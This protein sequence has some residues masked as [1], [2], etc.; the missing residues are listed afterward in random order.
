[1][2]MTFTN[3]AALEMKDR[4]I[5]GLVD[6]AFG[7]EEKA[8]FL[9]KTAENIE[10]NPAEVQARSK[11][12]IKR[13]LHNYSELSIQT[14]DKFNIRLIRTFTRDL[15][16]PGDFEIVLDSRELIEKTID[17]LID[18]IGEKGKEELSAMLVDFARANSEE[19]QSW[20]FRN[21]LIDFTRLAERES[22]IPV[23]A[24]V[25]ELEFT[26]EEYENLSKQV[27]SIESAYDQRKGELIQFIH[28]KGWTKNNF[29]YNTRLYDRL[30]LLPQTQLSTLNLLTETMLKGLQKII[31][32]GHEY[33]TPEFATLTLD[34]Y[35][36]AANNLE[37]YMAFNAAR[38]SFYQLALLRYIGHRVIKDIRS[39]ENL[40]AN[41]RINSLIADLIQSESAPFIY[42]RIGNRYDNYL[43]DEFQDTSRLQW[44]NLIPLVARIHVP[45]QS[46]LDCWRCQTGHLSFSK[47]FGRTVCR[48]TRHLQS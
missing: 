22:N 20:D 27:K 10:L 21:L 30:A 16:L 23:I 24:K 36:W 47:W 43:L 8:S 5:Q 29:K 44:L 32:E 37:R 19:E 39:R 25:N 34:F 14:I 2:A 35:T 17:T 3:K 18:S 46:E 6:L 11:K 4:V 15:D 26:K 38:K 31:H 13:I 45:R 12:V 28:H 7:G 42:E 41:C 9:H 33:L 48:S 40:V 1:M